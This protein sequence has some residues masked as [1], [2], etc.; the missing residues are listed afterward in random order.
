M[1]T[2]ETL[3]RVAPYSDPSATV[4][5]MRRQSRNWTSLYG[6]GQTEEEESK[7]PAWLVPA[8][9]GAAAGFGVGFFLFKGK[10]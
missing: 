10:R 8:L 6:L 7:L 3:G 9:V 2:Q 5:A 4:S 1:Y